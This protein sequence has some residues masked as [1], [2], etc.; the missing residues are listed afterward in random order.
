MK[1]L[2]IAMFNLGE[3]WSGAIMNGLQRQGH[4][5]FPIML[6]RGREYKSLL[7]E[8]KSYKPHFCLSR[9]FHLVHPEGNLAETYQEFFLKNEIPFAVWYHDHPAT[10]GSK[11][12]LRQWASG[13]RPKN[14]FFLS[15]DSAYKDYFKSHELESDY[16]PLAAD[17]RVLRFEKDPTFSDLVKKFEGPLSY[18]GTNPYDTGGLALETEDQ[19]RDVLA[20]S[21][22]D[23][24][25]KT[26]GSESSAFE[27]LQPEVLHLFHH[28]FNSGVEFQEAVSKLQGKITASFS[29]KVAANLLIECSQIFSLYSWYQLSI[30]LRRLQSKGMRVHGHGGWKDFLKEYTHPISHLTEAE[31]FAC[32]RATKINFCYTKLHFTNAV[33]ERVLNVLM[34]SGF[35]L[36]DVRADLYSHFEKDEIATYSSVEELPSMIDYYLQND[37]ARKTLIEKGHARVLKQHTYFH[38]MG[39][40]VQ[41]VSKHFGF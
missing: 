21:V 13:A 27:R 9:N 31:M 33:H 10:Q 16:L 3:K 7:D 38:R 30:Y 19:V 26:A 11:E 28:W 34:S 29:Q 17:D 5:V 32:F 20:F 15:M 22:L 4:E 36:T 14:T 12:L 40:L 18:V 37:S 25:E 6:S 8:A 2:R 1:P 39:E 23:M 35:P 24:F 41:K